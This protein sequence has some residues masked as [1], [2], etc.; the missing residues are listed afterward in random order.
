MRSQEKALVVAF[1]FGVFFLWGGGAQA[2]LLYQNDFNDFTDLT[3]INGLPANAVITSAKAVG[4]G[5]S[6]KLIDAGGS[7]SPIMKL[8]L[9]SMLT[10]PTVTVVARIY[11][12]GT[13]ADTGEFRAYG[14]TFT[15]ANSLFYTE[16]D[17]AGGKLYFDVRGNATAVSP[18]TFPGGQWV[19]EAVSLDSATG[20]AKLY[21]NPNGT[22]VNASQLVA[23][24][25]YVPE[26]I[27]GVVTQKLGYFQIWPAYG[28]ASTTPM[29]IDKVQVFSGL[30]EF[31]Q[32]PEPGTLMLM[33]TGVIGLIAYAWRKRR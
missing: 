5:T 19:T 27:D 3:Q 17:V 8:T 12:E 14:S 24:Q 28:S 25:T 11:T 29:Y 20:T 26:T 23:T 16:R 6:L 21:F 32:T 9:P 7:D 4:A 33:V 18:V 31:T 2:D 15:G 22:N 1:V 13:E 30:A 10:C